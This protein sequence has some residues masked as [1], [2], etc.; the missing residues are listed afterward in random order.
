MVSMVGQA[1]DPLRFESDSMGRRYLHPL[2][3]TWRVT[4]RQL[5]RLH[6]MPEA[7]LHFVQASQLWKN[8]MANA[9][10][11]AASVLKRSSENKVAH[12]PICDL[13]QGDMLP[14]TS[15][16]RDGRQQFDS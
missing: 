6:R 16:S 11:A 13:H 9:L 3:V 4:K 14:R 15:L 8:I 10:K 7:T 2:F 5:Q 1:R 12:E